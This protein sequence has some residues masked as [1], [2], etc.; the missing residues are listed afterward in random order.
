MVESNKSKRKERVVLELISDNQ[1]DDIKKSDDLL[2]TG[3]I[4][5]KNEGGFKKVF[6]NIIITESLL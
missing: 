5:V 4:A 2:F 3:K 6:F 1:L